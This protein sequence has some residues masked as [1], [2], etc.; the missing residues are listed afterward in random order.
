[1][2][3]AE[4]KMDIDIELIPFPKINSKW[5]IDLNINHKT[6]KL[7]KDKGRKSGDLGL[8]EDFL[9]TTSET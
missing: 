1:M 9:D 6:I 7:L 8:S 4:K 3:T 2:F 5:I